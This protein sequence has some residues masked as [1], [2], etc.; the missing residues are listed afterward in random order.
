VPLAVDAGRKLGYV[1]ALTDL[2]WLQI[3]GN[4]FYNDGWLGLA[5][6]ET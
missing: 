1:Y 2:H 3:D 6:L 5:K 4:L